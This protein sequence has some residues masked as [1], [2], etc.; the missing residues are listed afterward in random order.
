MSINLL[1]EVLEYVFEKIKLFNVLPPTMHQLQNKKYLKCSKYM[2]K[3][4][5]DNVNILLLIIR[6]KNCYANFNS[7]FNTYLLRDVKTIE[8]SGVM[9][10]GDTSVFSLLIVEVSVIFRSLSFLVVVQYCNIILRTRV[11]SISSLAWL[12]YKFT[13]TKW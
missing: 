8:F 1:F 10:L 4:N 2:Y 5:E 9:D 13:C 12:M 7:V 11:S 3:T 6:K